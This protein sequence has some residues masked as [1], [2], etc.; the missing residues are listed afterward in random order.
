MTKRGQDG[1]DEVCKL[2]DIGTVDP[3]IFGEH[4]KAVKAVEQMY[5]SMWRLAVYVA[6]EYLP[7]YKEIS[8][9]A[10][11]VIFETMD[12]HGHFSGA[13]I[14]WENDQNLE[15]ELA[16]KSMAD[17]GIRSEFDSDLS[18]LGELVGR[19]SDE[20]FDTGR[21]K[22]F[23]KQLLESPD[24]L[25]SELRVKIQSALLSAFGADGSGIG[26]EPVE[27]ALKPR[28]E[29]V[30]GVLKTYKAK[31][32]RQEI[33]EFRRTHSGPLDKLSNQ[34]F[35]EIV[36]GLQAAIAQTRQLDQLGGG[37]TV[38]RGPKMYTAV[39]LLDELLSKYGISV[40]SQLGK[41]LFG[42]AK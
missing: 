2:K 31:P 19:L 38:H 8:E 4:E 12:D 30:I 9:T 29:R 23:P 26:G 40:S 36:S 37:A 25:P 34:D 17:R 28:T 41:D 3:L 14:P 15:K 13:D 5:G 24:G 20:L 18:P 22:D 35:E 11:R 32:T 6:P 21:L 10:G 27:G 1:E 39:E 16:A 42:D 7:R 33:D